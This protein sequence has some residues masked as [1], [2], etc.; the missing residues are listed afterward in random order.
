MIVCSNAGSILPCNDSRYGR[1]GAHC[2]S[3]G[4]DVV[5]SGRAGTGGNSQQRLGRG[6][7][8][9]IKRGESVRRGRASRARSTADGV[10][11]V[12]GEGRRIAARDERSSAGPCDT[13][14]ANGANKT[15]AEIE[16]ERTGQKK[17]GG[18]DA[19]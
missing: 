5:R 1:C 10:Y 2:R 18:P 7:S 11:K 14:D 8:A 19:K 13:G 4:G 12:A 9:R 6:G 17:T 15:R 16:T 3:D